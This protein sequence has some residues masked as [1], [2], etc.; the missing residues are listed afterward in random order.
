MRPDLLALTDESLIS[1]ANRGIVNRS[2]RDVERGSGPVLTIADDGTVTGT[3]DDGIATALPP[4]RPLEQSSC[5]CHATTVCRHR[6]MVVLAY[7]GHAETETAA[8]IPWSPAEFADER[9]AEHLGA[10]AM[11]AAR[12]AF[13]SGYRATVHRGTDE[14]PVPTVEL[15]TVTVRFLVPHDLGYARTDAADGAHLDAVALAV[16]AFRAADERAPSAPTVDIQIDGSPAGSGDASGLAAAVMPL[17]ELLADGIAHAKPGLTTSMAVARKHLEAVNARWMLD[18]FAALGDQ[19]A[20][21]AERRAGYDPL[22]AASLTAEIM[23]RQRCARGGASPVADVLGTAESARTPLKLLH[24]TGLGGRVTG[25]AASRTVEVYLAHPDARIALAV[26]RRVTMVPDETPPTAAELARR[27]VGGSRLSAIA[28]GNIV[29]HSASRS[30][31]RILHL[32]RGTVARTTIT[33]STGAWSNLPP[34]LL[35]GDLDAEARRLSEQSPAVIRPRLRTDALRVVTVE[36]VGA[37]HYSPAAQRLTAVVSAP[38]G[39]V[40]IDMAHDPVTPGALDAAATA[41]S[42][43]PR[44]VAGELRRQRG[45]LVLHPTAFAVGDSVVVPD[46]AEATGDAATWRSTSGD[47]RD[48]LERAVA[49][50]LGLSAE[51]LHHGLRHLPPGWPTRVD[52]AA[53]DLRRHGLGRCADALRGVRSATADPAAF[54]LWV[55]THLRLMLTADAL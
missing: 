52:A 13:R 27:T 30:A 5:T 34:E 43:P 2:A 32:G 16:W 40:T 24:L 6:V 50:A 42:G 14:D 53:D 48:P 36:Y 37:L 29:T 18:A 46:F 45:T 25:D 54:D 39:S 15:P 20:A 1:L 26:S 22:H 31:N 47:D 49:T 7:R 10:R 3:F 12:K 44:F 21:Y 9:L 38:V 28:T 4:G 19:L 17:A 33:A 35:V 8:H 23:A 41:L 51:V 11:A 55:D